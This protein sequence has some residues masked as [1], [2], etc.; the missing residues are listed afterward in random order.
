MPCIFFALL[1]EFGQGG[2]RAEIY[3]SRSKTLVVELTRWHPAYRTGI[4]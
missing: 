2:H 4:P 3:P 1:F